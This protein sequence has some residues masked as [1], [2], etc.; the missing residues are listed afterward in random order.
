[1][2]QTLVLA[3][4]AFAVVYAAPYTVENKANGNVKRIELR[5]FPLKKYDQKS[6]DAVIE[7]LNQKSAEGV[8][9][10]NQ[11]YEKILKKVLDRGF[12]LHEL[13]E[14][15]PA[16]QS[17]TE[18]EHKI[19]SAEK[20]ERK[21]AQFKDEMRL[22]KNYKLSEDT[23]KN[24]KKQTKAEV[25]KIAKSLRMSQNAEVAP[26]TLNDSKFNFAKKAE[27]KITQLKDEM[28]LPENYKLS[29]IAK[30]D[31]KLPRKSEVSDE[32][33][34]SSKLPE[35]FKVPRSVQLPENFRKQLKL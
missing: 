18:E 3:L 10:R 4:V 32:K 6:I 11:K 30:R 7:I 20:V 13:S 23:E 33:V 5:D 26:A 35:H 25:H 31:F 28:R 9:G 29:K 24:F 19:D 14:T 22:A 2:R 1:M 15:V 12:N 34:K 8:K 21:I 16:I 27:Y 17:E